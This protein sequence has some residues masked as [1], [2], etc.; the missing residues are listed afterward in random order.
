M[1]LFIFISLFIFV[2][3]SLFIFIFLH[4]SNLCNLWTLPSALSMPVELL[5]RHRDH[6]FPFRT[7][8]SRR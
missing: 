3:I 7:R 6:K 4:P 5:G 1:S 2:F 8:K